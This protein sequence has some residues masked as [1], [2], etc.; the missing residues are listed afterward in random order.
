MTMTLRVGLFGGAAF[1]LTGSA[2]NAGP[3]TD[4][5]DAMQ[6]RID[7]VLEAKA[8][9]GPTGKEGVPAGM[10]VQPTPRSIAAAEEKLGDVSPQTVAAVAQGMASARTADAAGDKPACDKALADVARVIGQMVM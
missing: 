4:A 3:C 10:G 1:I 9:A 5:V 2:A 7:A 8:A 6:A